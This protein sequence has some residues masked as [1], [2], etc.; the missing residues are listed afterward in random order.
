L[1]DAEIEVGEMRETEEMRSR[2]EEVLIDVR[3]S[4]LE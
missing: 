4:L 2:W 1:S 3:E